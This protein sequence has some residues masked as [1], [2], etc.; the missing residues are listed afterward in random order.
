M[1]GTSWDTLLFS[2]GYPAILRGY[3]YG[4]LHSGHGVLSTLSPDLTV[5][6]VLQNGLAS[7]QLPPSQCQHQVFLVAYHKHILPFFYS[8]HGYRFRQ[9]V[10][11]AVLAPYSQTCVT[12]LIESCVISYR[13]QLALCLLL[14]SSVFGFGYGLGY[15]ILSS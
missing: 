13:I 10:C 6:P 14:L 4:P 9:H 2:M 11:W 3:Q 15:H 12:A 5:F 8:T 7:F 1:L